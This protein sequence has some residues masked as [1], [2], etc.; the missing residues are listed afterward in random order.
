MSYRSYRSPF[1][2]CK[3]RLSSGRFSYR[4]G[5]VKIGRVNASVRWRR[6]LRNRGRAL[7]KRGKSRIRRE[8]SESEILVNG[9]IVARGNHEPEPEVEPRGVYNRAAGLPAP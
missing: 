5:M 7:R 3:A 6:R 1:W 4:R 8:K 2:N 9:F